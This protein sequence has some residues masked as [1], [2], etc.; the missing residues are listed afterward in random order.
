VKFAPG[1]KG[2]AFDEPTHICENFS[3]ATLPVFEDPLEE[4]I[5]TATDEASAWLQVIEP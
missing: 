2:L 4:P 3:G 5:L 1:L